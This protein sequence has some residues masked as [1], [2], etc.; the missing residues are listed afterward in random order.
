MFLKNLFFMFFLKL[1]YIQYIFEM[2]QHFGILLY[3]TCIHQIS[4]V[5]KYS[6]FKILET[7]FFQL[8]LIM[9]GAMIL[10][11]GHGTTHGSSYFKT[12]STLPPRMMHFE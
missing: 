12:Y 11:S 3:A 2:L 10:G 1:Y 9:I 5:N 7:L 4:I 8:K 6:L